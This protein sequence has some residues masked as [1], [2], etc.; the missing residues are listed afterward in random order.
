LPPPPLLL[1]LLLLI[2]LSVGLLSL[3][4]V[5]ELCVD[6]Q[7]ACSWTVAQDRGTLAA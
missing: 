5:P 4:A 1:L 2:E 3:L 6:E 7:F